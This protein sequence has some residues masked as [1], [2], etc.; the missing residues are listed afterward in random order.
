MHVSTCGIEVCN[1]FRDYEII[2]D[3]LIIY[4]IDY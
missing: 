2:K 1:N 3:K 4:L